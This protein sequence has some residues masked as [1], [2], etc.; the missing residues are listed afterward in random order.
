MVG[1]SLSAN[2]SSTTVP[3]EPYYLVD[4]LP[5]PT[6]VLDRYNRY[7]NGLTI[8]LVPTDPSGLDYSTLVL[9]MHAE[10]SRNTA[11]CVRV[12]LSDLHV[13]WALAN[14]SK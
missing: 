4:S 8:S 7:D 10:Y 2:Q 5:A 3:L 1:Y 14:S 13:G 12:S 9:C 11:S 6:T